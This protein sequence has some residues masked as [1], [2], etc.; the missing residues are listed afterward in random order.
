VDRLR[1][2]HRELPRR[3]QD[4]RDR[5]A[6]A[7]PL[8]QPLQDRQR[9][10]GRLAGSGRRLAQQVTSFEQRGDRFPLDRR[11]LLVPE[12]L[13]GLEQ[14]GAQRERVEPDPVVGRIVG[15]A[16]HGDSFG[17]AVCLAVGRRRSPWQVAAIVDPSRDDGPDGQSRCPLGMDARPAH[18]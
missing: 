3:H 14:F 6:A 15:G 18:P 13:Q 7:L 17:A 9:E 12:L 16:G 5:V 10:G 2:L 1:D 4:E 8:G 11:R